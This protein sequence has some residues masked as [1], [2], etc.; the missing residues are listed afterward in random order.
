MEVADD[1]AIRIGKR[2]LLVGILTGAMLPGAGVQA[3]R[4]PPKEVLPVLSGGVRYTVPH[5]AVLH[6]KDQDGGLPRRGREDEEAAL[7]G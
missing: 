6:G 7:I 5:A 1:E 4:S 2:A 3:K